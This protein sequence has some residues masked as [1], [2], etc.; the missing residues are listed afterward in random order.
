MIFLYVALVLLCFV[1]VVR[2]AVSL[3]RKD[4]LLCHMVYYQKIQMGAEMRDILSFIIIQQRPVPNNSA[5]WSMAQHPQ[6]VELGIF[7]QDVLQ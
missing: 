3:Y 1:V 7:C 2:V 6:M 4:R 5:Q